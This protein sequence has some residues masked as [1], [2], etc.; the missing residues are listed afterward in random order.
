MIRRL[1]PSALSLS[2]S[3]RPQFR[4]VGCNLVKTFLFDLMAPLPKVANDRRK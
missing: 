1:A 2:A 3:I 4:R